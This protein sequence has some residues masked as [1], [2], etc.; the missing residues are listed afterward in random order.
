MPPKNDKIGPSI[1]ERSARYHIII[2]DAYAIRIYVK[3]QSSKLRNDKKRENETE[4][5]NLIGFW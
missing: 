4:T 3:G 5:V 1:K 2:T